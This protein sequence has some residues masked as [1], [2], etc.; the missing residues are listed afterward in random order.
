MSKSVFKP[1]DDSTPPPRSWGKRL[2]WLALI[3]VLSIGALS[4]FAMLLRL[5]MGWVGL[6]V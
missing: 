4:L 5:V 2:G 1:L 3:W 6:T